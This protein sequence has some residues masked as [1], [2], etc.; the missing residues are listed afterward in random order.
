[1]AIWDFRTGGISL[2]YPLCGEDLTWEVGGGYSSHLPFLYH[3]AKMLG[4]AM[5]YFLHNRY[6]ILEQI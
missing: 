6:Q 4:P 1:M 3:Y 2:Y 5:H